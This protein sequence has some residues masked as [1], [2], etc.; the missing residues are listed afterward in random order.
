M[1]SIALV[2][3]A[4]VA[5]KPADVPLEP[6]GGWA[7][8]S[9]PGTCTA[10]RNYGVA[11]RLRIVWLPLN[12]RVTV[13]VDLK[14]P[15]TVTYGQQVRLRLEPGDVDESGSAI[16]FFP[17]DRTTQTFGLFVDRTA[18]TRKP[19]ANVRMGVKD[20]TLA[21]LAVG[22]IAPLVASLTTCERD[23]LRGFGVDLA[24]QAPVARLPQPINGPETWFRTADY[25]KSALQREAQGRVGVRFR[26][27]ADGSIGDCVAVLG[28][29]NAA[30]DKM[31]CDLVLARA[32]YRPALDRNGIPIA[33][34]QIVFTR[35]S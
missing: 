4:A 11:A 25:A 28:S 1:V 3:L 27:A 8:E 9:K 5:A 33:S 17:G 21:Y 12:A 13:S 35:W 10:S 26:V 22:D 19:V 20:K 29:G 23:M 2:A 6:T 15:V 31:T 14:S 34:M 16:G 30:L 32:R 18:L 24:A 7:L